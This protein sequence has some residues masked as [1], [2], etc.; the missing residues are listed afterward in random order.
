MI[1]KH[2]LAVILF[3]LATPRASYANDP[4]II[5]AFITGQFTIEITLSN[6]LPSNKLVISIEGQKVGA[7]Q[8]ENLQP[9][10]VLV[11]T[12]KPLISPKS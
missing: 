6:P 10:K 12:A 7:I 4:E 2:F 8:V 9:T 1:Q 11:K 3:L 5:S